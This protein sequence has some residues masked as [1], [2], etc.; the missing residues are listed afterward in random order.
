M[1]KNLLSYSAYL[2]HN[3]LSRAALSE[4]VGGNRGPG[5]R[6]VAGF[7]EDSI[8]MGVA[9]AGAI[10]SD[11]AVGDPVFFATASPPFLDKTNATVV[12][13]ALGGDQW[14][15]T[16][17]L[18]GLRSGYAALKLASEV[19]GLAVMADHR[20]GRTGSSAEADGGD[21][22][23]AF[24]F[25][26][27]GD[28]V[29]TVLASSSAATEVMDVWR[30]PGAENAL[31]SEERF[32]QHVLSRG[33]RKVVAELN[34]RSGATTA[35]TYSLVSTPQRR[36]AL[37]SASALGDVGG[38][39]TLA[40][41]RADTGYCG[42]A[43]IG[44]LLARTLD[45]ARSGDTILVVNA[46]GSVDALL[47]QVLR[48]GPGNDDWNEGLAARRS[49]SYVEFLTWSGRITREPA[50]RPD[51]PAAAAAPAAR[52]ADWKYGL[53]G[54]RCTKCGKV[55]LPAHRVC[56]GCGSVDSFT[57]HTVARRA[58][59]VVAVATDAVTDS[60]APPNEVAVVDFDG[61]GR[62]TMEVADAAPALMRVGDRI[63]PVFRRAY[64]VGGLPN[65]FWK[66][67]RTNGAL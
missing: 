64:E 24:V 63:E 28:P 2:P 35:P 54:G 22:A 62:L 39:E 53:V 30:A 19:G 34:A 52:N 61:G 55:Y 40:A 37:S 5:G 16:V 3:V 57:P 23:A 20:G 48:D 8:T 18:A 15:M 27:G 65:Y 46:V 36:L 7:D 67:R 32:S 47:L 9:A 31:A 25:G 42:A 33:I 4:A 1:S 21:G 51:K 13:A 29:A 58:G 50:R 26:D 17:D 66:A 56:G 12:G 59:S 44:V 45:S 41:H 49:L 10:A 60:P 43:D 14:R 6:S 11:A 38:V